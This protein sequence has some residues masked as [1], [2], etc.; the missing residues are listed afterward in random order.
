MYSTTNLLIQIINQ[1]AIKILR[2][3]HTDPLTLE[4]TRRVRPHNVENLCDRLSFGLKRLNRESH[5]WHTLSHQNIL[6]FLGI[7]R[8]VGPSP[9]LISPLYENG[10]AI[11]F[12][13]N[14][15]EANRLHLVSQIRT[16]DETQVRRPSIFGCIA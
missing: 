6:S 11:T 7:S 14:H 2:G 5:I 8:D 12:V 9:A 3:L 16:L 13:N 10:E 1:V 4:M 15:P